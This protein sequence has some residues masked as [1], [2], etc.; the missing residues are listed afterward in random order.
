MARIRSRDLAEAEALLE[1]VASWS[2]ERIERL[3]KFYREKAR[4]YRQLVNSGEQENTSM[5]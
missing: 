2:D 5:H 4:K 3:P 1:E